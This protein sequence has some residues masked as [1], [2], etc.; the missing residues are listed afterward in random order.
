MRFKIE[1]SLHPVL[2]SP[3]HYPSTA[4]LSVVGIK[5]NLEVFEIELEVLHL[6]N[7]A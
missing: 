7:L 1:V 2:S 3:L 4:L 5:S 6:R